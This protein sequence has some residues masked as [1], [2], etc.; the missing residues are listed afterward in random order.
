MRRNLDSPRRGISCVGNKKYGFR[1]QMGVTCTDF[2]DGDLCDVDI[3][4]GLIF[5]DFA[6]SNGCP[7]RRHQ[8]AEDQIYTNSGE[9]NSGYS[10]NP[11]NESPSGHLPLSFKV[12]VFCPLTA[13][14]CIFSVWCTRRFV[15]SSSPT[16]IGSGCSGFA[17]G[18]I[19]VE[20]SVAVKAGHSTNYASQSQH[21]KD[22]NQT[23][24]DS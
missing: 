16:F 3:R 12:L 1:M 15:E 2:A 20:L 5:S 7:S 17:R 14:S 19:I 4:F 9:K 22:S 23:S 18:G 21:Q 24:S 6:C 10:D 11:H 13:L 8:S